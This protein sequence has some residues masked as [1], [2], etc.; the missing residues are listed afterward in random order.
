MRSLRSPVQVPRGDGGE[1]TDKER[2]SILLSLDRERCYEM[3]TTAMGF[4]PSCDEV[5]WRAVHK[6]R[7]AL[8]HLP[9]EA[10]EVSEKWLKEHGSESWA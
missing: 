10:R 8:K 4:P 6:A 2:D 5:M 1:V 7:T 3:L 9:R